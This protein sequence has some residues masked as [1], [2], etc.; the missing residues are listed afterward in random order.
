MKKAVF[1]G[2][3]TLTVCVAWVLGPTGSSRA[4]PIKL[5]AVTFVPAN[6]V[7]AAGFRLYVEMINKK[8]KNQV[9]IDLVGGP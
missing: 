4:E 9:Q 3:V 2:L 5:K 1:Y 6:S 7:D 8:F